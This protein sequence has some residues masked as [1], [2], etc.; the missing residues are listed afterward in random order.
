MEAPNAA[1]LVSHRKP[2]KVSQKARV[3][4]NRHRSSRRFLQCHSVR[5]NTLILK[6]FSANRSSF[7][8]LPSCSY[9]RPSGVVSLPS[10]I[11]GGDDNGF[12]HSHITRPGRYLVPG[13]CPESECPES[14]ESNGPGQVELPVSGG[15]GRFFVTL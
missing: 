4:A 2:F 11:T 5:V 10:L 15:G 6:T 8:W 7:V 3:S 9:S 12:K 14:P 1:L 13:C